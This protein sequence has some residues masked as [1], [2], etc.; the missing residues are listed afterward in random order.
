MIL[1]DDFNASIK[2]YSKELGIDFIAFSDT[3]NYN[4]LYKEIYRSEKSDLEDLFPCTTTILSA[5]FYY[6]YFWNNIDDISSGF[7]ASYTV[8]NFYKTLSKK[9]QLLARHISK[10]YKKTNKNYRIFVN[11]KIDDKLAAFS[12]GLGSYGY[13]SS[14]IGEFGQKAVLGTVAFDFEIDYEKKDINSS[15]S[16]CGDCEL[17]IASCPMNAINQKGKINKRHCLHHLASSLEWER[18]INNIDIIDSWGKRFF[19]C[20][21]CVSVCPKNRKDLKIG[22]Q[23]DLFGYIGTSFDFHNIFMFQK[24][25]YKTYFKGNQLSASWI[26][27]VTLVRNSLVSLHNQKRMD[28]VRDYIKNV[29]KFG[30]ET[31]EEDYIKKFSSLF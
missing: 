2:S 3:S 21:R 14:I 26:P 13:N 4:K 31:Y 27:V 7:I 18:K 22:V 10:L 24:N 23:T 8:A 6:D 11:S 15:F 12:V 29:D 9:L 19:G 16:D 25:D 28:L 5:S 17:C 1:N 20:N 30:F